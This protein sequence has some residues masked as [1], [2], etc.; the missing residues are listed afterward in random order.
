MPLHFCRRVLSLIEYG[1]ARARAWYQSGSSSVEKRSEIDLSCSQFGSNRFSLT[2][3]DDDDT[4]V[5]CEDCG[6]RSV[7]SAS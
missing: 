7:R 4:P 3:A 2:E 5:N 1:A 6:H